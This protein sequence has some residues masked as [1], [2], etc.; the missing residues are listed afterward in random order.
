MKCVHNAHADHILPAPK[1][2][3]FGHSYLTVRIEKI[4]VK[5]AADY[6]DA[7]VSVKVK[8]KVD[9]DVVPWPVSR[10]EW[11]QHRR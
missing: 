3:K 10:R 8:G 11:K 9:H 4:G 5:D 2:R 6:Q 7:Y 1:H